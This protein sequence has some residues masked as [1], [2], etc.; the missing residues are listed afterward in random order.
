M[1]RNE[2]SISYALSFHLPG[3]WDP[4]IR[5]E[6]PKTAPPTTNRLSSLQPANGHIEGCDEENKHEG[7]EFSGR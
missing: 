1:E 5:I 3:V 4:D 7:L 6:P 2:I